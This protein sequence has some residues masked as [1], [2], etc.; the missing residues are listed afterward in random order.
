MTEYRCICSSSTITE[1]V[2]GTIVL[3]DTVGREVDS[4]TFLLVLLERKG[5]EELGG[6]VS[7]RE[8]AGEQ[9][10]SEWAEIFCNVGELS[11]VA[12]EEEEASSSIRVRLEGGGV[13]TARLSR[14]GGI[15]KD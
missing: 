8:R 2:L 14:L 1:L 12:A 6:L 3:T 7:S 11:K 15:M 10:A 9:G 13:S 5:A 4:L